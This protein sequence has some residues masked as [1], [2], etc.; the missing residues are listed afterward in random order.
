MALSIFTSLLAFVNLTN[1]LE[2]LVNADAD[3][4]VSNG[5]YIYDIFIYL[6]YT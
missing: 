5:T 4:G 6:L 2:G 3:V 1:W